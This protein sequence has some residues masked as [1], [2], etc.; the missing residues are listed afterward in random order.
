MRRA[1]VAWLVVFAIAITT[2]AGAVI[3]LNSTAFGAAGF[4]RIYLEA[5]A[6]GDAAG[7]LAMAGVTADPRAGTVFLT[8]AALAGISDL[9]E[10]SVEAD[11]DGREV[12]T[13]AWAAGDV[14]ATSRFT[15]E[16]TGSR[17]GLFPKWAFA[18]SPVASLELTVAHD[19]RF[20]LNGVAAESGAA[21][22][23]VTYAVLV[24]GVYRVDHDSRYLRAENVDVV[25]DAAGS[26]LRATLDVQP[27]PA[28]LGEVTAHVRDRLSE[29]ATHDV[30]FPTG[31]PFGRAI[32]NRVVSA[33]AWSILDH[34][35]FTL[36]P[37]ETFGTWLVP[38]TEGVA[39]LVVDV[40]SLFDGSI[41]TFDE[42]VRF[43]VS[44]LVTIRPGDAGLGI[45]ERFD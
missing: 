40:Q 4:V 34:P 33:P 3:A 28:M 10:L 24:P 26:R 16:R 20:D 38:S 7:A 43:T 11:D 19:A 44:Y 22:L 6:R 12:V 35:P 23:A 1:V 17:L 36:E 9:R 41:S 15:V 42:D 13:F 30:L 32:S 37:G 27:K 39:H 14:E 2:S 5:I 29:C 21:G 8:D 25:A 18:V 31:C 45:V